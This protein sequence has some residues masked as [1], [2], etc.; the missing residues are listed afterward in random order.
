MSRE[1]REIEALEHIGRGVHLIAMRLNQLV[2]LIAGLPPQKPDA[3]SIVFIDQGVQVTTVSLTGNQSAS[4]PVLVADV[5]GNPI[6]GDVLD[7]GASVVVAD[8]T[9]AGAVLSP[10]QTSLTV[11]GLDTTASTT[12]TVTGTFGGA[13]LTPG[14]LIIDT[15]AATPPPPVPA[16]IVFGTPVVSGTTPAPAAPAAPAPDATGSG[17]APDAGG[18]APA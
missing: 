11:T 9:V 16:E 17:H 12:A 1:D 14:V 13:T 8:P 6:P 18:Q 5:D 3:A 15:T 10:D 2:S 4:V 7:P